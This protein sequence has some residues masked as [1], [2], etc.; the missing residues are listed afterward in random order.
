MV[1]CSRS[2]TQF[3]VLP[4]SRAQIPASFR[5]VH[6]NRRLH[7][8]LLGRMQR[9]RGKAYLAD[10]AIQAGDLTADGRHKLNVDEH[11]WHVLSLN[12]EGDVVACLRYVEEVQSSNFDGL[13]VRHAALARCPVLGK[14]FRSAVESMMKRAKQTRIGFG[15]VGGW[16]VS[17]DHRWTT[18][19][20]RIIL[21]TYGLLQLLGSSTGVATA[22]FR[23]GSASILRRIGLAS[24]IADGEELP[25]YF[26]PQYG[27]Q[28]EVLEF[29]SR[30][31]NPKY[32]EK[33]IELSSALSFAPVVCPERTVTNIRGA[34]RHR[35]ALPVP[36]G[37]EAGLAAI[38]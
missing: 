7:E 18:E 31:P 34:F 38:A 15:E 36:A 3:A 27:C 28:M 4:P 23:H 16:A 29:D 30:F 35:E 26:D 1:S 5:N 9:M 25:P 2:Q 13:W 17:E 21:A 33:V 6:A 37:I 12:H 14:R 11:S 10:G 32:R 19:P 20:L 24:M 22:T 8:D